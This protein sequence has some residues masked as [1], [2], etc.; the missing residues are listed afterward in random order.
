[1]FVS[2][3]FY[4]DTIRLGITI[5]LCGL[6]GVVFLLFFPVILKYIQDTDL[7]IGGMFL[8]LL[9]CICLVQTFSSLASERTVYAALILMF[10]L[11]YPIGHTALIGVFSKLSKS[12]P[13]GKMMGVFGSFG[14]LARIIFPLCSGV[15][16]QNLGFDWAFGFAAVLLMISL[17]IIVYFRKSIIRQVH[18]Q[19]D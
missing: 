15:V 12:G 10:A 9:S 19:Y 13:Q 3:Y 18:D 5:S 11:G 4:W 1:M 17:L 6:I 2:K 8:M 14:S 7:I 16:V